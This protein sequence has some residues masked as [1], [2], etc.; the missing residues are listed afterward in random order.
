MNGHFSP[1]AARNY[2]QN[3]AVSVTPD[4]YR[5]YGRAAAALLPALPRA[6]RLDHEVDD[7]EVLGAGHRTRR[8]LAVLWAMTMSSAGSTVMNWPTAPQPV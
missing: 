2:I 7:A 6:L 4:N 1:W 8:S 5:A 3:A